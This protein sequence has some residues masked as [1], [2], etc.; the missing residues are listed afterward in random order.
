VRGRG[1]TLGRGLPLAVLALALLGGPIGSAASAPAHPAGAAPA[2]HGAVASPG[3]DSWPTYRGTPGRSGFTYSAGPAAPRIAWERV[4]S[5]QPGLHLRTSP[6][7]VGDDLVV[8]DDLGEV[9]ALNRSAN[10]TTLWRAAVGPAPTAPTIASDRVVFGDGYGGLTALA[11]ANGTALWSDPLGAPLL[12]APVVEN[13]TVLVTTY[14]GNVYAVAL[15]DGGVRWHRALG[16]AASGAPAFDG[17]ALYVAGTAGELVALDPTSGATNWTANVGA[18]VRVGP[19]AAD[20]RVLLTEFS[21]R[22]VALA[23]NGTPQ[24]TFDP[25]GSLH[26][27]PIEAPPAVDATTAYLLDDAGGIYAVDLADGSL[28][29]QSATPYPYALGYNVTSAPAITPT[30]LYVV[31]ALQRIAELDPATGAFDWSVPTSTSVYS[32]AAIVDGALAIGTDLDALLYLATPNATPLEPVRLSVV[33]PFG[34]PAP[35]ATI[36]LR[37]GGTVRTGPN[38]SALVGLENGSY[39]ASVLAPAFLPANFTFT[40]AGPTTVAF[41]LRPEPMYALT[42]R[43]ADA[44]SY[45]PVAGL[46]V[47]LHTFDFSVQRSTRTNASGGFAFSAPAGPAVVEVLGTSAYH[48]AR[49]TVE[50]PHAP[51]RGLEILVA[52]VALDPAPAPLTGAAYAAALPLL[53]L[54]AAAAGTAYWGAAERRRALGRPTAVL[55]PFGRFVLMRAILLVV[56]A[57]VLLAVLFLFG[58]MLP[59]AGNQL[60]PCASSGG[61]CTGG[62]WDNPFDVLRAFAGGWWT[63]IVNMFTGNWGIAQFGQET[64]PVTDFIGWW[65]AP[66]IELAIVALGLSALLAYPIGLRAGWRPDGRFDIGARVGGLLILLVPTFLLVV[67]ALSALYTSFVAT[68]GDTPYGILPTTE[69]FN[70]HGGS[71]AW[72]GIAA[73]TEPTGFPLV[74]GALHGAWS[75]ELIVLVKT[76]LQALLIALV[77]VGIFLRYARHAVVERAQSLPIL[78]ARARGVPEGTLLWRHAGREVLPVYFL[79]FGITLPMYLGTQAVVETLFSDVGLGRVLIVEMLNIQQ[80]GFGFAS[81]AHNPTGNLYQVTIF[82]LLLVVLAASLLSDVLTHYLDPRLARGGR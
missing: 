76:L 81:T 57:L 56:Q 46:T 26:R 41:P 37:P 21:G 13:G 25:A 2:V 47:R 16:F 30:G 5:V 72:V 18:A 24:W 32:S 31:D 82:L 35:N 23:P 22:L 6:A 36:L 8:A 9:Y 66:S 59:A 50:V 53:A 78:A 40:V 77:Y 61:W 71:P 28:R 42:G 44:G 58:K 34:A 39:A 3:P 65:I 74:D 11:L 73:N 27:G 10:G 51:V 55:S 15:A 4:L 7:I 67:L 19:V 33:D 43:V 62:S 20:G 70:A 79:I 60:P 64:R 63:F 14:D 29:W 17:S 52:P 38:G 48:G 69:W 45:A 80:S 1:R 75:V 49:A 54:G 68:F 12:G